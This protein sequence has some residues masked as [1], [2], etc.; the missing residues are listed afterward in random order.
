MDRNKAIKELL[1]TNTL[2]DDSWG[3]F[4][5]NFSPQ[6]YAAERERN[7]VQTLVQPRSARMN[8]NVAKF[9]QEVIDQYDVQGGVHSSSDSENDRLLNNSWG[10]YSNFS[11]EEYA[12]Q[13]QRQHDNVQIVVQP[14]TN[15][16]RRH[17]NVEQ[18]PQQDIDEN[19]VH[20][21][22]SEPTKSSDSVVT[23]SP[24]EPKKEKRKWLW[25]FIGMSTV[26]GALILAYSFAA[27]DSE[28]QSS[29]TSS[30]T[31]PQDGQ[32]PEAAHIQMNNTTCS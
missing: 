19:D 7:N 31:K 11:Q 18:L 29:A 13:R 23:R 6:E 24:G 16:S 5:P 1:E 9:P 14:H 28:H 2:P 4:S 21:K 20:D 8:P 25:S 12:S 30:D 22:H 17:L 27:H 15:S 10:A 32:S 3:A 26:I